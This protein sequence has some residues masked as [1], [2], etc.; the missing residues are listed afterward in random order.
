MSTVKGDTIVPLKRSQAE[1]DL[2]HGENSGYLSRKEEEEE[3]KY[4]QQI[5]DIVTFILVNWMYNTCILLS[6]AIERGFLNAP[7]T[8]A[9]S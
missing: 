6:S 1:V 8:T 2:S 7:S 5:G 3:N 4:T 9:S